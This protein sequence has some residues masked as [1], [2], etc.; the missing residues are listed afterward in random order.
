MRC[1]RS[2]AA[3]S[4]SRMSALACSTPGTLRSGGAAR[5]SSDTTASTSP[6]RPASAATT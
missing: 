1:A 3:K 4:A 5:R 2:S 6:A